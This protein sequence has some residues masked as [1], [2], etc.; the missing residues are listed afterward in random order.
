MR[1]ID[2]W[3]PTKFVSK[4]GR[5]RATTDTRELDV[6]SRLIG[7]LV[8]EA[9]DRAFALHAAGRL[10][11]MGCGKVPFYAAY[12]Q[13]V[14]DVQCIDWENTHH[15]T[16][17]LDKKCDL[18][19]RIP[20]PDGAFDTILL[21]DVLEHLPEPMNCWRE[22]NRL[23]APGGKVL[24][25]V[26]FYYP[27]HEGPHDFY[28]YTEFALRRFA[29]GSGF[30]VVELVPIGGPIE[31]LAD[32]IAKLFGAARMKPAAIAVQSLARAFT[33]SGL[34]SRL[35]RATRN[36]FPLGYFMVAVK[37]SNPQ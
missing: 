32:V 28:R 5:L 9:Y 24:L 7:D 26:P 13:H 2:Q 31:I 11:D 27:I 33:R 1:N 22:M 12:R 4:G 19:G 29:E 21:S 16:E 10:C 36:R 35:L 15:R 6:S 37:F 3:R 30:G 25:N 34:G 18:T 20:Y 14:C 8:A 17:Y 23:L